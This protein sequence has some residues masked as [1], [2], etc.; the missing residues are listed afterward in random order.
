MKRTVPKV[1]I[2][3]SLSFIPVSYTHLKLVENY[4]KALIMHTYQQELINQKLS[5]D[6]S[7]PVSYTHLDVY[8][9]QDRDYW[10]TAQEAKEYGMID[11]VLIKK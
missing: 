2:P 9:R 8:K 1:A 3:F 5:N 7:E 11:E 10:M 6:I 4:R